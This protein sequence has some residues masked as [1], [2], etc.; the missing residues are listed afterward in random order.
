VTK[1]EL[2]Q[3]LWA[4]YGYSY[5]EDTAETP[6]ESHRTVPSAHAYYPMKI[7][8]ANSSGVYEYLPEQHTLDTIMTEDRRTRI[9]QA[10]GNTWASTS[11]VI[12]ALAY[13]EDSRPWIGGQ[14]TYVEIG[15]VTQN[16]YLESA[17][18]GLIADWGKADN[19]EEAMRE[20]LGL[21]GE[22]NLHPVSISTI[23]HPSIYLHTVEW[24]EKF[25]P[26]ETMSD[27]TVLNF[28]FD[29]LNKRISFTVTSPLETDGFCNVTIP[30]SLLRGAFTV[31]I[32]GDS[33]STMIQ[34]SNST[35]TSLYFTYEIS[36][37]FNVQIVGEHVIPEFQTWTPL[38]ISF[39]L[40]FV[41][42]AYKKKLS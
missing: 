42:C 3:V 4:S 29:Q 16:I 12:I 34:N 36:N 19:D 23:G 5:Y 31:L 30:D 37:S 20:A 39:I 28:D 14:E 25:Y 7:Y 6:S 26:I 1:Q 9:A 32:D 38:L 2:S 11:P 8:I 40:L 27:S 22:T 33:P 10:S 21:T 41:I 15:L 17:A 13:I 24:D 18:C 35:H